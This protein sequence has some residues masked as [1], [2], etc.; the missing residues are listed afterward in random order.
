MKSYYRV[1]LGKKSAHAEECFKNDFIGTDFGVAQDLTSK[2]TDEWRDFNREFIPVYLANHP[3]KTRIGAGL[4][5]GALWTVS[6]GIREGDIVLC[7][8]GKG[9]YRAAEVIGNYYY[10]PG[11]TLRHRRK[12][13]WLDVVIPR[14]AMSEALRSEERRV[15]KEWRSRWSRYHEKRKKADK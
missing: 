3:N 1:M 7:P 5:C 9:A 2:L 14:S 11:Q 12:V 10:A 6:K 15:G 13:R 4:A 8:D